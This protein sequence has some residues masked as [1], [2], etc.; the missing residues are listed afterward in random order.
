MNESREG[1]ILFVTFFFV[2]FKAE[3]EFCS[4][5]LT[6][7]FAVIFFICYDNSFDFICRCLSSP[8]LVNEKSDD[9]IRVG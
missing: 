4:G 3:F 1:T 6:L 5:V 8:F 9:L 2:A 7:Y